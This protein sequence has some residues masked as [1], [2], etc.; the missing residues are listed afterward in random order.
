MV[1]TLWVEKYRPTNLDEYVFQSEEH[2]AFAEQMLKNKSIPHL[3]LAGVQGSGKTTLARILIS[4][5]DVGPHDVLTINASVDR[6]IDTFRHAITSFATTAGTGPFKIVHLEEADKLTPDA[7]DALK[8]FLEDQVDYVRFIFSCNKPNL[9]TPPIR[10]RLQELHFQAPN[11]SDVTIRVATILSREGVKVSLPTLDEYVSEHYPDMRRIINACQQHSTS[12][13]LTPLT[14]DVGVG[15]S[16]KQHIFS[17]IAA[18]DWQAVRTELIPSITSSQ[19]EEFY[20]FLYDNIHT[21]TRFSTDAAK[22]AQAVVLI[23]DHLYRHTFVA[24]PEINATA[25]IIQL[26]EV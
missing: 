3:L 26:C 11:R 7:Q 20:R 17:R 9:I 23:A 13:T 5:M 1:H 6:G 15:T 16:Y 10:S 12:G 24:D 14:R 2:R 18:G 21:C 4:G 25:L 8:A 19:W 22:Q